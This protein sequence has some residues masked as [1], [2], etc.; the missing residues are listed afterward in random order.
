MGG[1]SFRAL[2]LGTTL[3]AIVA[4][5]AA[6]GGAPATPT[7]PST[8]QPADNAPAATSAQQEPAAQTGAQSVKIIVTDI[9]SEEDKVFR[10]LYEDQVQRF[11]QMHPGVTVEGVAVGYEPA[12][13]AAKIAGGTLEHTFGVWYTEPQK[14]IEQGVVADITDYIKSWEHFNEL[15]PEALNVLKDE[16]GRIYGIPVSLYGLGIVYNRKIFEQAGL[17]PDKPPTTWEEVRQY[18]K[19]IKDTT[20]VPGFAFL[21]T[22]NQGGWH[23]TTVLYTFGGDAQTQ[24]DAAWTA[25]FNSDKG[26]EVLQLLKEMRWTDNSMTEEQLLNVEKVN[27]MMATGRLGMAIGGIPGDLKDKYQADINDFGLAAMPQ[28]GANATLGGGYAFMFNANASPEELQAAVDWVL[29]RYFDLQNY[30]AGLK[31]NSE[32]G[33]AIGFPEPPLFNGGLQTQRDEILAKYANVPS[34]LY[35]PFKDGMQTI[36]IRTEPPIEVQKMYAALDSAVQAVL[37][38]PNAEPKQ[39]LDDTAQQFQ[40]QVLDQVTP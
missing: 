14:F 38:D 16:Q 4:I 15:R 37:T 35:A 40:S 27:E 30:E 3:A 18:A 1:F 23:F 29:F 19:Q 28:G 6:C 21:S 9:P 26:L 20:G 11:Q 12:A 17:D 22:G 33:D 32:R 5:L 36:T 13:Y 10:P 34:E 7:S 25:A 8:A 31:L 39:L 2:R 24:Q